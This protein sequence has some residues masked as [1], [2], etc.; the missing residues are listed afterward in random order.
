MTNAIAIMELQEQTK[1]MQNWPK[2]SQAEK[3]K[4]HLREN[5]FRQPEEPA[6]ERFDKEVLGKNPRGDATTHFWLRWLLPSATWL[7]G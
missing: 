3:S 4:Q 2:A 5:C 1:G 6:E 7:G